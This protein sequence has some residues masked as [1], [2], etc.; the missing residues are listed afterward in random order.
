MSFDR[1]V[2]RYVA[3]RHR[4]LYTGVVVMVVASILIVA[5]GCRLDSEVLNLLPTSFKTV[6]ALKVYNNNFTDAHQLTFALFDPDHEADLTGFT[7]HFAGM[8][9]KEPWAGRVMERSPMDAPDGIQGLQAVALPLLLNIEP[10]EFGNV[11]KALEPQKI[12]ARL[13]RMRQEIE[14]GSMRAE[15]QM[16]VDPLGVVFPALKP[17]S[18]TFASN[19]SD[20]LRSSD[21]TLQ[22]VMVVTN[23]PDIGAHACQSMMRQ[24]EDFKKRVL[25]SWE[26]KAPQILVTGR[27]PY[28][29]EMSTYMQ[30]DIVSTILGS[31]LLVAVV[32]YAGF[33]RLR[34]LIAIMHV[35]LLCCIG[36][37]ALGALIFHELNMITIGCC[38]ILVG[39]GV[40]FGMLL[41]GCYQAHRNAGED[42][43]G[44]VAAAI[45]Q[46][47]KGVFFGAL[48]TA[49]GFISLLISDTKGFAQLGVLIAIGILLAAFFMTTIFFVFIG[50]QHV[51]PPQDWFFRQTKRYVGYIFRTPKPVLIAS[52]LLLVALN[53][54]AFAP[55]GQ[56]DFQANPKSLEPKDS[57]AGFA[58]RTI[59]AKMPAAAEPVLVIAESNGPQDFHDKWT[60]LHSHWT[61]L[62]NQKGIR[63]FTSPGPYAL[64]PEWIKTNSAKLS[65]INLA[66]AREALTKAIEQNGYNAASFSGGFA[67]IDRLQAIV[68]GAA[69]PTDWRA[70][71]PPSS[72]WW[73]LL[74]RFFST[75][76]NIGAAYITPN[77]TIANDIEKEALRKKIE[78]PGLSMCPTGWSFTLA[79]LIPWSKTKLVQLSV[80]MVLFNIALLIFIYRAWSPLM[81]LMLS[82][83]LSIGAM[84]ACLKFFHIPLNLFNVLAFPLV[85]GVGVDYGIYVVLAVRQPGDKEQSLA[86]IIK[87][88]LMS[89]LTTIA[90]F[91]SLGLAHNPSLS[92]LGIVCAL[93][94]AWCLASTVFFILPAYLWRGYR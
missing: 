57:R 32:F 48:T 30:N 1:T 58:L 72:I 65:S 16:T 49:A 34:P 36:A 68:N 37:I 52:T 64:S 60:R 51:P 50:K 92:G 28:V 45:R 77:K 3:H 90:G 19:Q 15:M 54:V 47:G 82:L 70:I 9:K 81:I 24:V 55:I 79:D 89:G 86:T 25:A 83:F 56:I 71:L 11:I 21:D 12:E 35:L 26:G 67:L 91:G 76:P 66:A 10:G 78:V 20:P 59:Q 6:Q 17:L 13:T 80:V 8:A 38:S 29:A 42:H 85:L 63:S 44:A 22:L 39:L 40:D 31:V 5:F 69:Q 94:V 74:D 46:L 75:N 88:V 7:E 84:I 27:T 33:R 53:I 87:P 43:E 41:Y 14:A 4:V 18:G 23:Q 62:L 73:F 61:E 93:G 2:A